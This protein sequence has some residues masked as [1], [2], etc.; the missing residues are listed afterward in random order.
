MGSIRRHTF[1]KSRSKVDAYV[2]IPASFPIFLYLPRE[3]RGLQLFQTTDDS[4]LI[5]KPD[6]D[7]RYSK[8]KRLSPK[9]QK[10]SFVF[11]HIPIRAD[12]RRRFQFHPVDRVFLSIRF[13]VPDCGTWLARLWLTYGDLRMSMHSSTIP[14]STSPPITIRT[15]PIP[16]RTTEQYWALLLTIWLSRSS[17]SSRGVGSHGCFRRHNVSNL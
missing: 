4:L 11:Q 14:A 5:S 15:L 7:L 1:E 6:Y 8:Q 17:I 10:L 12:F 2:S 16:V 13:A 3:A 9:F